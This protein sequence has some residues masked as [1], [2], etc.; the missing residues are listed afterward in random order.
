MYPGRLSTSLG[1]QIG[2]QRPHIPRHLI[3][4]APGGEEPALALLDLPGLAAAGQGA[5]AIGEQQGVEGR[6]VTVAPEV[7]LM[8]VGGEVPAVPQMLSEIQRRGGTAVRHRKGL[9]VRG[10]RT[11][12]NARTRKGPRKTMANKNVIFA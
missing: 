3:L 5:L 9:P 10:Q 4:A 6:P 12:T 2:V 8:A 11:K 1:R 7:P